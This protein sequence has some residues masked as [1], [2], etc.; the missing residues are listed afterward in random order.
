MTQNLRYRPLAILLSLG[1]IGALT[2]CAE[3]QPAQFYV[4]SS[5]EASKTV[6]V[7]ASAKTK[8]ASVG[9]GP[10]VLPEY[11]DRPQIVTRTSPTKLSLAEFDRWGEPLA[12][13][14]GRVTAENLSVL[15]ASERVYQLPRRGGERL[16]YRVQI[17]V[18]RFDA[19]KSGQVF[20]SARWTLYDT[21]GQQPLK[22]GRTTVTE[23]AGSAGDFEGVAAALSRAV[24]RLSRDIAREIGAR[25]G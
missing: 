25:R 1:L 23:A 22:V 8:P 15:L 17:D 20:L 13:L 2:A 4:L 11:L 10:I 14:L 18:F 12:S 5:L 6:T 21:R 16:D 7:P 19:D 24:E 3:T 9:V